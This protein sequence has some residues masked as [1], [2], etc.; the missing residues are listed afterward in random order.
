MVN[1]K[2]PLLFESENSNGRVGSALTRS[3]FLYLAL[4]PSRRDKPHLYKIRCDNNETKRQV[5]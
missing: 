4:Y 5:K 1:R 3:E 2:P